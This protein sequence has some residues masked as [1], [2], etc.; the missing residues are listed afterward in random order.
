MLNADNTCNN[1]VFSQ[2]VSAVAVFNGCLAFMI[3]I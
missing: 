1:E 3:Y 2:L